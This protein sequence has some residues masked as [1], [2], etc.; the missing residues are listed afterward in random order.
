MK[1]NIFLFVCFFL[2]T[3]WQIF[4]DTEIVLHP[5]G[6]WLFSTAFEEISARY[7]TAFMPFIIF[8]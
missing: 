8:L 6:K 1:K 3:S 7:R 4:S 2:F 5:N